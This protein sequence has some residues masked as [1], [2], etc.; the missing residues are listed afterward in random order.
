MV[1]TTVL[2]LLQYWN[3]NEIISVESSKFLSCLLNCRIKG[4]TLNMRS[5]VKSKCETTF[6]RGNQENNVNAKKVRLY[7]VYKLTHAVID[8]AFFMI[9]HLY[10]R[11]LK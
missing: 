2:D 3:Q 7:G 4:L 10:A 8:C 5:H 1:D 11:L 9:F 6:L